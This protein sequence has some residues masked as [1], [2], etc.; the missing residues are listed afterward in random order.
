MTASLV[1]DP[2]LDPR[3]LAPVFA[4]MGRVHLPAI[5]AGSAATA[6]HHALSGPVPWM[7]CIRGGGDGGDVPMADWEAMTPG[8]RD[9]WNRLLIAHSTRDLQ[10]Q[11]DSWRVSDLIEAGNRA[12]GG[13]A[14][15]EA[16]YDF[17]NSEPFLGF[18]RA[19]TGEPR[20][21]FADAQ[22]TRYRPGDFL[23][24]H[25]DELAGMNRLY[26]YVLNFTPT[27]M[28]DWGGT[29]VFLDED[30]H[31]AEGYRPVFNAL[32][33]FKVPT[34][35]AVTQVASF[36]AADRLSITGWIRAR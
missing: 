2:A 28:S 4:R 24:Q 36:A 25:H 15:I 35:H 30:G 20:C 23:A 10:F 33:L 18:V 22:A 19:L 8:R 9:D 1:I 5:F 21:A 3:Q 14:P 12:G 32:N 17:L 34:P 29:L 11:F 13:L 31:V 16:V 26:A 27:W 6:I 7:K